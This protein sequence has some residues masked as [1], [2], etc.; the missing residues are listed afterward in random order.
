MTKHA[1]LIVSLALLLGTEVYAKDEAAPAKFTVQFVTVEQDVRLEV[2]DWGGTG[3]PV[4]LLA[5]LGADAHE[6]DEFAPKLAGTNHVYGITRRGFGGSSKPEEG[7]SN[8]RLGQDIVAV[9]DALHLDRP[10]LVG[11]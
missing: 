11:H 2:V 10:V 7:Y 4:V 8:D 1:I 3:R 9:I 5:A 6:F